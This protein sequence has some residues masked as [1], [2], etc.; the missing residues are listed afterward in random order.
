MNIEKIIHRFELFQEE[1]V[2]DPNEGRGVFT[3]DSNRHFLSGDTW[4]LSDEK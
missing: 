4:F 2:I 1:I 3:L